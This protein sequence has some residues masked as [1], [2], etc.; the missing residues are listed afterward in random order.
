MLSSDVLSLKMIDLSAQLPPQ[1]PSLSPSSA[2]ASPLGFRVTQPNGSL[3]FYLVIC[4]APQ[5]RRMTIALHSKDTPSYLSYPS[6]EMI[7]T[8]PREQ[9]IVKSYI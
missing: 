1:Y 4:L 5:S 7:P 6:N 9:D 3:S 8:S 2:L